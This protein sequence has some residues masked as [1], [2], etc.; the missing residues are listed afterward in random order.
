M[1][2]W[3]AE[4]GHSEKHWSVFPRRSNIWFC[5]KSHPVPT[6]GGL[7]AYAAN[8]PVRYID[9]DGRYTWEQFK[10]EAK[11]SFKAISNLDFGFDYAQCAVQAWR[12]GNYFKSAVYELDATC[13]M[14][15]DFYLVYTGAKIFG[16]AVGGEASV[17]T[18]ATAAGK[19]GVWSLDKFERGWEIERRLGGRMNN[20]P[21]IDDFDIGLDGFAKYITSIK[22]MDLACKT[23]QKGSAVLARLSS[24][25]DKVANFQTTQWN[26]IKVPVNNSTQR[27]LMLAIPTGATPEQ[28][29]AIQKAKE[30][31]SQKGVELI[32][33]VIE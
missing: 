33:R 11:A 3:A 5:R 12:N 17:Y 32:I 28:M 31:A 27:I 6:Y 1:G 24:Y 10:S 15:L 20:F 8:N 14:V 9:P 29:Q 2:L 19:S 4:E 30:Y 25:I 26:N 22:S 18:S 16:L 23:Y 13:E 21:V 7:Y